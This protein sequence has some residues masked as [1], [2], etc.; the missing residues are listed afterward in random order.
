MIE[1]W[2]EANQ[3]LPVDLLNKGYRLILATKDAW[4]LDHGFWGVTKYHSWRVAY[5]NKIPKTDGVLGGETAMWAEL[6]DD[7]SLDVKV[8]PRAAAV[9]ERLWSNPNT[10]SIT[11]EPRLQQLRRRLIRKGIRPDAIS[12][13][14]CTQNEAQC[15]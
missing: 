7:Q 1:T 2:V 13:G 6:V 3:S 12:P 9:A 8:W 15:F 10:N 14:Y 5:D 4:Y 11:A